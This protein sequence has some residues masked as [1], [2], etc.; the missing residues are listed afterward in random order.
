MSF[1]IFNRFVVGFVAVLTLSLSHP[2]LSQTVAQM[3]TSRPPEFSEYPADKV[4]PLSKNP[5]LNV[6]FIVD[7]SASTPPLTQWRLGVKITDAE[8]KTLAELPGGSPLWQ[9][10]FIQ[11]VVII[12]G[13]PVIL[14]GNLSYIVALRYSS[15]D[16]SFRDVGDWMGGRIEFQLLDDGD[17]E[18][19]V[20]ASGGLDVPPNED[21]PNAFRWSGAKSLEDTQR[22]SALLKQVVRE[23]SDHVE[24]SPDFEPPA[25]VG[26]LHRWIMDCFRAL[27]AAVIFGD[28]ADALHVCSRARERIEQSPPEWICGN[29]EPDCNLRSR[30]SEL[31][32]LDSGVKARSVG[33]V[34]QPSDASPDKAR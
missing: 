15:K 21:L 17:Y 3:G 26:N 6:H 24:N 2:C 25:Y 28:R 33:A 20:S 9:R 14:L 16:L 4:V 10:P 34:S 13:T 8:G 5:D 7:A 23:A 27:D 12:H 19:V 31:D 22:R 32:Q 30:Q 1:S 18:V 29:R 11:D